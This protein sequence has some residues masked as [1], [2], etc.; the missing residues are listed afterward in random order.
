MRRCREP[1]RR[2][3]STSKEGGH[4]RGDG[5]GR[6][7]TRMRNIRDR[8]GFNH[9]LPSV[10]I[11]SGWRTS[12]I[13]LKAGGI[14]PTAYFP[15]FTLSYSGIIISSGCLALCIA[16]VRRI[17]LIFLWGDFTCTCFQSHHVHVL[18]FILFHATR[19]RSRN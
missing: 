11:G 14:E 4:A 17:F 19:P 7:S 5:G 2:K 15:S 6:T 16:W 9:R 18:N 10:I 8:T 13:F 1:A 12:G 3:E